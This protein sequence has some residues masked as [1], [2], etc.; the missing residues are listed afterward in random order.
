LWST[1]SGKE[2]LVHRGICEVCYWA[3][4]NHP[5]DEDQAFELMKLIRLRQQETGD[6]KKR[7]TSQR[8]IRRLFGELN[9]RVCFDS[10]KISGTKNYNPFLE[11]ERTLRTTVPGTPDERWYFKVALEE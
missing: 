11:Y 1:D 8:E 4:Y 7:I 2:H 10:M 9:G 5:E 6:L 3:K